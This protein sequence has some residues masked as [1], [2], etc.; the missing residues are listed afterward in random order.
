MYQVLSFDLLMKDIKRV[1][2]MKTIINVEQPPSEKSM[3]SRLS[4]YYREL[5][6]LKKS[7]SASQ[8][9]SDALAGLQDDSERHEIE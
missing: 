9:S 3:I 7:K 6:N 4:A 5:Q 2:S 8:L 1:I